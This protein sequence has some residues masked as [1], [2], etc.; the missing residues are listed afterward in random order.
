MLARQAVGR[1]FKPVAQDEIHRLTEQFLGFSCHL[2]EFVCRHGGGIFESGKQIDIAMRSLSS[3]G[4][5]SENREVPQSV[6]TAEGLQLGSEV[7]EQI[8][9]GRRDH[10]GTVYSQTASTQ[11]AN[12]AHGACFDRKNQP[13]TGQ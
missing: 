10:A 8:H 5:G 11:A 12:N 9:S 2:E 1:G 6:L 4:E 3:S 13:R 7:I